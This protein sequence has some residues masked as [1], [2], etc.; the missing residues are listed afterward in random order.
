MDML[1]V[2]LLG[3]GGVCFLFLGSLGAKSVANVAINKK[4]AAN[5]LKIRT[6]GNYKWQRGVAINQKTLPL[7]KKP[8]VFE[9]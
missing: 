7:I 9:L 2:L 6:C 4:I 1:W 3:G 5:P 8:R